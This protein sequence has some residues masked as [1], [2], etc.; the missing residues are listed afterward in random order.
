MKRV[1]APEGMICVTEIDWGTLVVECS[2]GE[3]GRRFTELAC[4]ELRN[5]LIARQLAGRLRDLGFDRITTLAEVE[6]ARGLDAFHTWFV[7]PS[8]S[9]FERIGAFTRAE[10]G[11]MLADLKERAGNGYYFTSRTFH[12]IVASQ[13]TPTIP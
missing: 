8:L 13:S 7:E 6:V 4:R 11:F 5:G 2:I 9:H 3:L 1:L 12:S 10:A